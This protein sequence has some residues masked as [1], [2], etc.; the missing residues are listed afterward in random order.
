MWNLLDWVVNK[1]YG[2]IDNVS[3]RGGVE[4]SRVRSG[5]AR[6]MVFAVEARDYVAFRELYLVEHP[7][8]SEGRIIEEY[9]WRVE[10]MEDI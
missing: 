6:E 1:L 10:C 8:D 9:E 7:G 2:R 3:R 4:Y 5:L